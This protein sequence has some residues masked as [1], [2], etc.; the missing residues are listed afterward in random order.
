MKPLFAVAATAVVGF[1]IW[2]VAAVL[3]LPLVGTVLGFVFTLVKFALIGALLWL[4]YSWIT[5]RG[6]D[7]GGEAPAA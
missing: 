4:A 7:K 6:K 1:A 5:R 2:K 3:L